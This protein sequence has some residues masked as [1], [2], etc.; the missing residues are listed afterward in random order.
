MYV[1]AKHMQYFMTMH[2]ACEILSQADKASHVWSCYS[3]VNPTHLSSVDTL[4]EATCLPRQAV[5]IQ[6]SIFVIS[7]TNITFT[8]DLPFTE[9]LF[10]LVNY[11]QET[12]STSKRFI[13]A[14]WKLLFIHPKIYDI[15]H[16]RSQNFR[17]KKVRPGKVSYIHQKVERVTCIISQKRA[18][19]AFICQI[20]I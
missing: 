18:L 6:N 14:E 9:H 7:M 2:I 15:S 13:A 3:L 8:N 5:I 16:N 4:L 11:P 19:P 17:N 12:M 1:F 10:N 20:W